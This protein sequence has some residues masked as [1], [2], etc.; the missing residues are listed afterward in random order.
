MTSDEERLIEL[1][2]E[3]ASHLMGLCIYALIDEGRI[4]YIGR[5]RNLQSRLLQ[6]MEGR[7]FPFDRVFVRTCTDMTEEGLMIGEFQPEN[8]INGRFRVPRRTWAEVRAAGRRLL[9][10]AGFRKEPL[11]RRA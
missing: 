3:D 11:V 6:H 9:I 5:T 1:G 8:N 2:F 10:E 4:V 7:R